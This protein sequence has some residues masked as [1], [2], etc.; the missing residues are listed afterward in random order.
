MARQMLISTMQRAGKTEQ[1]EAAMKEYG[2][3]EVRLRQ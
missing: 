3:D 1:L 2:E